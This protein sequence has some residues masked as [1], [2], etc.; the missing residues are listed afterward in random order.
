M[1]PRLWLGCC[2]IY[3]QPSEPLKLLLVIYISAYLADRINIRLSSLPLLIPTLVV[4]GLALLLLLVQRDLGTASIFICIF[5]IFIFLY[6]G[7]RR[8]LLSAILFLS[9]ALVIGYFFIDIIH[10]RVE[11]WLNPW[12]DPSGRSYQIVQSLLAVANGGIIG[13]GIGIGSPLLVPV[14]I[15]DFIFAAIAE[16]TGLVGTIGLLALIWLI[17]ARGMIASLRATEDFA[18][19]WRLVL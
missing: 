14:A 18:A 8:V 10:I 11:G 16:E 3:F 4:T 15:S 12:A 7:K 6:T 9:I 1:G 5:T 19:I 2:G 17:L 13:R